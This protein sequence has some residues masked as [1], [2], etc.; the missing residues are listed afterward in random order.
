MPRR[1]VLCVCAA[2]LFSLFWFSP[3]LPCV[4]MCSGSPPGCG[5]LRMRWCLECVPLHTKCVVALHSVRTRPEAIGLFAQS[6]TQTQTPKHEWWLLHTDPRVSACRDRAIKRSDW[7]FVFPAARSVPYAHRVVCFCGQISI[8]TVWP[9][10]L[11]FLVTVTAPCSVIHGCSIF[12]KRRHPLLA[13]LSCRLRRWAGWYATA[14]TTTMVV[15]QSVSGL[16]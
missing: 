8:F 11:F 3:R 7:P 4:P 2:C 9:E 16:A 5:C 10:A 13:P 15:G 12:T 6:K 14:S 1:A